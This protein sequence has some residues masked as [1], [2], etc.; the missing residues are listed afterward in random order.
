MHQN[1]A[2]TNLNIIS[3]H[4]S[5]ISYLDYSVSKPVNKIRPRNIDEIFVAICQYH[6]LTNL[7]IISTPQ[8]FNF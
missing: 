6:A 7:I 1:D 8:Q 5:L 4:H 3:P 2:L